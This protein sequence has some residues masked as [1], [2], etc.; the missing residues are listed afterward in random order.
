M[1]RNNQNFFLGVKSMNANDDPE[2][3]TLGHVDVTMSLLSYERHT[4][5]HACVY[6]MK[7]KTDSDGDVL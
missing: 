6:D 2:M 1:T 4:Y 7:I 5:T 3:K